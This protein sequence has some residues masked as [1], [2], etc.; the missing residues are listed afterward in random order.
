MKYDY[1]NLLLNGKECRLDMDKKKPS[2]KNIDGFPTETLLLKWFNPKKWFLI[3]KDNDNNYY[4]ET[5]KEKFK[6]DNSTLQTFL[7]KH[8]ISL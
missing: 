5:F 4:V 3:G 6:C 2:N 7:S 1:I 8:N